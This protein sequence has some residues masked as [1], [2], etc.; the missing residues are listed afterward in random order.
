LTGAD[1]RGADLRG[2]N[3]V[4]ANLTGANLTGADLR[5]ADLRDAD[6]ARADL[7]RADLTSANL[8]GRTP[9]FAD[10]SRLFVLYVMPEVKDGPR[11]VAGCRNFTLDKARAHWGAHSDRA[12]PQ[13]IEA[14]EAFVAG[15]GAP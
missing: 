4:N 15:G 6:L 13:Y 5:G 3:L 9:L 11:F 12:R 8:T 7:A 1:L 10:T 14:I 2:A